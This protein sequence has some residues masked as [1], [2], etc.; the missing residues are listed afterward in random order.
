MIKSCRGKGLLGVHFQIIVHHWRKSGQELKQDWNLEAGADAEAMEGCCLLACLSWLAQHAFL[1]NQD[2]WPR[3]GTTDLGR[4]L[5]HQSLIEK[6]PNRFAYSP[7]V[8]QLFL[9]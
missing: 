9:N 3:Y 5:P 2:H 1:Y 4:A 8:W 6:M 7:I